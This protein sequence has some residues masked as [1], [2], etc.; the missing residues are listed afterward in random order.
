M[1]ERK[2]YARRSDLHKKPNNNQKRTA[3]AEERPKG[4]PSRKKPYR[5]AIFSLFALLLIV[6]I[7]TA[8]SVL[9]TLHQQEVAAQEKYEAAAE[10][11]LASIQAEQSQNGLKTTPEVLSKGA[12]KELIYRPQDLDTFPIKDIKE[13]L[14]QA[15]DHLRKKQTNKEVVTVA[16]IQAQAAASKVSTYSLKAD[17]YVWNRETGRFE[18]ADSLTDAP[19]FVSE[20]TQTELSLK[21]LVP[22][23]GSLL[24]IQQVIQQ[25]LLDQ[26]K[27]PAKIIDAVLAMERITFDSK[28]TYDP[29]KLTIELPKNQTEATEITLSYSEIAPF[30]DPDLVAADQLNNALPSLDPNKKYVALTFDDGPNSTSTMDLLN[31]LQEN[32]VKATFFMLGQMVEQYPQA[33]KKVQEAGHEIASHSYSHPQLNTLSAEDLQAEVTKTNKAIYNA[34]GLLPRNL[35]PPYG[36][37]DKQSAETIGMP[38]IQWDIDSQDWKLKDPKKINALVQQNVFNGAMIL[39]HD[40]HPKSVKAVPGVIKMLKNEGYEFVT[41]DQLLEARQKPLHQYFGMNDERLVD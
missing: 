8:G 15:A 17:S 33:A 10:K 18:D 4:P 22:D 9:Y 27:E 3:S 35:R 23:E 38:I 39:I 20:K 34:T 36:A 19:I 31:I 41:V 16:R 40:I 24:G 5:K 12:T 25:K 28:F 7:A 14:T 11:L 13:R 1:P 37:I 29:E 21:E 26:A 30:I 2:T 6:L 32:D